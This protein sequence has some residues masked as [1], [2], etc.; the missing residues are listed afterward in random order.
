MRRSLLYISLALALVLT[1]PP[2]T[3][4][5]AAE[6][7][8]CFKKENPAFLH[9]ISGQFKTFWERNGGLAVFGYP[10]STVTTEKGPAGDLQVQ[11]FERARME[12]HP[13][14]RPPY[15]VQLTLL[16]EALLGA[17]G[18]DWR[19][20]GQGQ[21]QP[22]CLFFAQTSHAVCGPFLSYYRSH[23]LQF[24]SHPAVRADESLA[25]FGLPLT[26]PAME[27]A[28]DGKEYLT[29]WFERARFELHPENPPASR[30][31]LGLLGDEANDLLSQ[32]TPR[33]PRPAAQSR[34]TCGS[35][36]PAQNASAE[37]T[38]LTSARLIIGLSGYQPNES[39]SAWL[40]DS[41]GVTIGNQRRGACRLQGHRALVAS[42][43]GCRSWLVDDHG[44]A[45]RVVLDT[46]A[47]YPGVWTL[48]FHS[49]TGDRGS[50]IYFQV[51]PPAASRTASCAQMPNSDRA[52]VVQ[53]CGQAGDLFKVIGQG[54]AAGEGVSFFRTAP[55]GS[56]A[57]LGGLFFQ[58]NQADANG[59][60]TVVGTFPA[61]A[62]KGDYFVTIAA[63]GSAHRAV[64]A[65]RQL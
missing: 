53:P 12:L 64:G 17:Q 9:C 57:P 28:S 65:L 15:D 30:V 16:G 58:Q 49:K 42:I 52:I 11:W 51:L 13:E 63:T 62:A 7:P 36:P 23:G 25:L 54:F 32:P 6:K 18:R 38:C 21:S 46:G 34:P 60:V 59:N 19:A 47:L 56:V 3:P 14:S 33:P 45:E 40:V 61:D 22:G 29:Q 10:L 31:L 20:A 48:V 35:I 1:W 43:S 41:S 4:A 8:R 2:A 24:D 55:D 26:E 44:S 27:R 50:Q 5:S 37:E 39:L